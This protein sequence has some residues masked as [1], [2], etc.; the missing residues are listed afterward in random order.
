[1]TIMR[2]DSGARVS[3]LA[4]I[5][6]ACCTLTVS[7]IQAQDCIVFG[8][9]S[10]V[11]TVA[12]SCAFGIVSFNYSSWVFT[13]DGGGMIRVAGS[14]TGSPPAL[15]GSLN[16]GDSTFSVEATVPGGCT[17]SYSLRGRFSSDTSWSGTF[18][19]TFTG[20]NCFDCSNQTFLVAG[21]TVRVTGLA[22]VP[23]LIGSSLHQNFPNPFNP[24]TQI[25]FSLSQP[26]TVRLDLYNTLG[27]HVATL[28]EGR[29]SGGYHIVPWDPGDLP[30]GVYMYRLHT[31]RFTLT[32]HLV[33]LR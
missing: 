31:D 21:T 13:D 27:Q 9:Y 19:V 25:G 8:P 23:D 16:C 28:V 30:A 20:S 10:S 6:L 7:R 33:F 1:M 5:L 2:K 14:P 26:G 29:L 22:L 17:E 12:Y 24:T 11:P 32:K 4:W 3:K 18:S 15:T